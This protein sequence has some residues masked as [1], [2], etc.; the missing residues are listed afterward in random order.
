[1]KFT[2]TPLR[3]VIR[4][5]GGH[6][7]A[8]RKDYLKGLNN[9]SF[10]VISSNSL[11]KTRKNITTKEISKQG[12]GKI[13]RILEQKGIKSIEFIIDNRTPFYRRKSF[14]RLIASSVRA[15]IRH[16][17]TFGMRKDLERGFIDCN[18]GHDSESGILLTNTIISSD[19][20]IET[21][22]ESH[23]I[24]TFEIFELKR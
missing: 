5:G 19:I 20:K 7:L 17:A 13:A 22:K 21:A 15:A 6:C 24:V 10:T 4:R 2:V 23:V 1:M 3:T 8:R 18:L 16:L 9:F 12:F 11:G 14:D